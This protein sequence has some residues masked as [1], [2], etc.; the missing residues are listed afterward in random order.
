MGRSSGWEIE[1]STSEASLKFIR[2]SP[3]LHGVPILAIIEAAPGIAASHISKHMDDFAA[4]HRLP[5]NYMYE[6]EDYGVGVLKTAQRNIEYR[7]CLEF[8]LKNHS[9]AHDTSLATLHPTNTPAQ[10]IGRLGEMMRSYHWD[11]KKRIITSKMDNAPDDILSA[12]TQL[13][14][15]GNV[16]W[17]TPRYEKIRKEIVLLSRCDFPF[18]TNGAFRPKLKRG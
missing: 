16:F 12:L 6:C 7:F 9:L 10:E 13:L 8:V 3:L 15:W 11:E 18:V 14:Y 2:D 17:T 5:L 1:K 4:E